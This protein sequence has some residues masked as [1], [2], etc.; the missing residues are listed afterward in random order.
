MNINDED[1]IITITIKDKP[2]LIANVTVAIKTEVYGWVTIKN[3]CIWKSD[4]MNNRLQ[5][6]INITPPSYNSIGKYH[7]H[8]F[9]ED[10]KAWH[11]LEARI[12]DAYFLKRSE[13]STA[14][15]DGRIDPDEIPI[16]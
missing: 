10:E 15:L 1:L 11:R 13:E 6:Y 2:K 4:L 5:E 7:S 14:K 12:Y 16:L 8:V 3:F 9:F